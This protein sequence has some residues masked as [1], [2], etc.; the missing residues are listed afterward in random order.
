MTETPKK[1]LN[2]KA[3]FTAYGVIALIFALMI[4]VVAKMKK[5]KSE[6]LSVDETSV[7]ARGSNVASAETDRAGR[8]KQSEFGDGMRFDNQG[9][10]LG[11]S[12]VVQ[13]MPKNR[14]FGAVERDAEKNAA[15]RSEIEAGIDYKGYQQYQTQQPA[16]VQYKTT[17][18]ADAARA[19]RE[20]SRMD[21]EVARESSLAFSYQAGAGARGAGQQT[22]AAQATPPQVSD[23]SDDPVVQKLVAQARAM[24]DAAESPNQGQG[25]SGASPSYGALT[26]PLVSKAGQL[27][28]MRIGGRPEI[29]VP[30]GKF[31]DGTTVGHIETSFHDSPVAVLVS[32]DFLDRS[33]QWVLI[34][35]GARIFGQAFRVANQQQ[36]RMFISFHR[37]VFPDG[38]SA[39]F[40]ER[41]LPEGFSLQGALG[42]DAR[43]NSH[44]FRRFGSA[45]VVGL[46]EGLAASQAGD[47]RID[48][49]G[50]QTMTAEQYAINAVS[51]QFE[52]VTKRM[53]DHYS[54][55]APT[56]TVKAGS[57]IKVYLSEDVVFSAYGPKK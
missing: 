18:E 45:I 34:P 38:R 36:T 12:V 26:R 9:N 44:W 35:Q 1:P 49:M 42:A 6:P 28:D 11:S 25:T 22:Q 43:V 24:T 54:N 7:A 17:S 51:K 3:L 33:G 31:I 8:I 46:V 47:V 27:A 23:G 52:E 55:L 30:E 29:T 19:Q 4:V 21:R 57:R 13:D 10:L 20:I 41:Q 39:Y 48:P 40:P 15:G 37:I 2:K 53:M 50:G 16:P 56:I 32:R 14:T 5:P